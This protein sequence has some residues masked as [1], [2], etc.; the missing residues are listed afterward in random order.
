MYEGVGINYPM[1]TAICAILML[2]LMAVAFFI[3]KGKV[4]LQLRAL[5]RIGEMMKSSG[6][7]RTAEENH[8][9]DQQYYDQQYMQAM[10]TMQPAQQNMDMQAQPEVKAPAPD[11]AFDLNNE[12]ESVHVAP[13]QETAFGQQAPQVEPQAAPQV[14]P[15][16]PQFEQQPVFEQPVF[17]QPM[18]ETAFG[19]QAPQVEPQVA[20]QV[21]PQF[22][23]QVAPQVEPQVAPQVEPQ[24]PQFEQQPVFEKPV[25]SEPVEGFSPED[26][27]FR[28]QQAQQA[29]VEQEPQN[30]T[31]SDIF[32]QQA[33]QV[34]PQVAPQVEP[35]QAPAF[36]Q[37]MPQFNQP[38]QP[39]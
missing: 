14:E 39:Q 12:M 27:M 19:Q 30:V 24:M 3:W 2:I 37:Q 9:Y 16:M 38:Q 5:K 20:P 11:I 13:M 33:P 23:P 17:E 4:D 34:E 31:V 6:M 1:I 21:E 7:D 25:Q 36:E 15:Q 18:Q 8:F 10:Q 35:Q 26:P 32:G 22:A 28:F 29:A